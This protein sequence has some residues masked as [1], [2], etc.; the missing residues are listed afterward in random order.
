MSVFRKLR[1][2]FEPNNGETLVQKTSLRLSSTDRIRQIIRHEMLQQKLN[3]EAE[4]F[5]EADD[6]EFEDGE[7]WASPYEVNFEPD[8]PGAGRSPAVSAPAPAPAPST[9][10]PSDPNVPTPQSP[11]PPAD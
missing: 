10:D 4:S 8:D 9:A 2:Y 5:D 3:S 7:E 11:A 6:F 1:Q